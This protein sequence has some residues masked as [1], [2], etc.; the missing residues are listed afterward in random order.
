MNRLSLFILMIPVVFSSLLAEGDMDA[1]FSSDPAEK[2]FAAT[3]TSQD[4]RDKSLTSILEQANQE[5][6]NSVT[7]SEITKKP[8]DSTQKTE[9]LSAALLDTQEKTVIEDESQDDSSTTKS[10]NQSSEQNQNTTEQTSSAKPTITSDGIAIVAGMPAAAGL[11]VIIALLT[12]PRGSMIDEDQK[13]R[14][15]TLANQL[16]QLTDKDFE[17]NNILKDYTEKITKKFDDFKGYFGD[18]NDENFKFEKEQQFALNNFLNEVVKISKTYENTPFIDRKTKKFISDTRKLASRAIPTSFFQTNKSKT[19][20]LTKNFVTEGKNN[21]TSKLSNDTLYKKGKKAY[22]NSI[23]TSKNTENPYLRSALEDNVSEDG[24]LETQK[25][26]RQG[27]E[28]ATPRQ[29][30]MITAPPS[31]EIAPSQQPQPQPKPEPK[32]TTPR[33]AS[34]ATPKRLDFAGVVRAVTGRQGISK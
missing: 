7:D 24:I 21:K 20:E 6:Q 10:N 23:K 11:F 14:Y 33:Q 25:T 29:R 1:L 28:N 31:Q 27:E 12:F 4:P 15:K 17:K 22:K 8:E 30:L 3:T 18:P 34:S 5:D 16:E 9:E 32:S 26:A 19:I 2:Q 13:E